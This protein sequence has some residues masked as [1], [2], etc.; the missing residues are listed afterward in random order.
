M[1]D[2]GDAS[3]ALDVSVCDFLVGAEF[4]HV[5]LYCRCLRNSTRTVEFADGKFVIDCECTRDDSFLSCSVSGESK[6]G[7]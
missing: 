1:S 4:Y 2:D 7:I 3:G 6:F 5:Q